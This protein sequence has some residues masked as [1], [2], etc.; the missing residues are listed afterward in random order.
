SRP[1][2]PRGEP[3]VRG[4]PPAPRI[5]AGAAFPRPASA[6]PAVVTSGST[7]SP[8]QAI[9]A[10]ESESEEEE[11]SEAWR[12][13]LEMAE[14][15]REFGPEYRRQFGDRLSVQQDRVLRELMVCRTEVLGAHHWSCERCGKE[16]AL[17]HSC[18]NRHCPKCG[19]YDRRLWAAQV[20]ADLLP[21][22]Y[23]HVVVTLPRPLTLLAFDHPRALYPLVLRTGAEA[24][25]RLA[26]QQLEAELGVL[27][28][29]HSWGQLMNRHVHAHSLVSGGGLWLHGERFIPLPSGEFLSLPELARE[30]R[31][32]FLQ[33]LD[34]L[35]RRGQL[36]LQGDWRQ[37]E[38]GP[39]WQE[40][41]EPLRHIDWVVF[42]RGVWDRR[43]EA[44]KQ[45]EVTRAVEYLAR[46]ANRIAMSNH[47]LL[48]IEGQEVLFRY[49]DHRAGG[50]WQTTSLPGVEFIERFLWHLVPQGLRRI[51][52]F[53]WWG[54]AVRTAKLT[55]LRRLLGV[56]PPE[57]V[58]EAPPTQREEEPEEPLD[59]ELLRL[60]EE[61]GTPRKCRGC[62]GN[63]E[64]TYQTRRPTVA[65]LMRMPPTM[66]L[67]VESGPVQLYLPLSAFL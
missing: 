20:Q 37:L 32:L 39:A 2:V 1:Q 24:I 17:F 15:F 57:P 29:L 64:L 19:A 16:V 49:Q 5:V 36:V 56:R 25:L 14:V 22:E 61:Q 51:R 18:K 38:C 46:Y 26:R 66:E 10:A 23:E 62:G 3:T 34:S 7:S 48:A 42:S 45:G 27:I 30:F 4:V 52:R 11:P 65:E 59:R 55:L 53:G 28:L 63:M 44:G 35:H 6:E 54:N 50:A 9:H 12:A 41:L 21:I 40:F 47:R 67:V 58:D 33:R 8:A 60:E 13:K 43:E 31:D